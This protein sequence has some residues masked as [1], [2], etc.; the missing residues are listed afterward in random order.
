[1]VVDDV[2]CN[3]S[4]HMGPSDR[5]HGFG[6]GLLRQLFRKTCTRF[7]YGASVIRRTDIEVEVQTQTVVLKGLELWI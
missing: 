1:M 4:I 2:M 7:L 3:P 6:I 5:N